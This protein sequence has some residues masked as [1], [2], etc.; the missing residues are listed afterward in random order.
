[1]DLPRFVV[2]VLGQTPTWQQMELYESVQRPGSRTSVS[3]GHGSGKTAAMA[4]VA[5]WMLTTYV[6]SNTI[7]SGPKLEILLSG[8]RKYFSDYVPF[9]ESGPYGWIVKYIVIA[10]KTIYIRGFKSQ[11][12]ITA[13]TAPSGKPEA[14]AGEHRRHLTWLLDESSGVD[15]KIMGVILGSLTEEW[16]RIALMSQPTRASG[17]FYD[18]HHRLSEKR[19]GAWR[20]ITM[21][22]EE[23]PLVSDGFIA[24]KLMQ[25]GGRDDPQ[26]QIKVLGQFPEN[27]EGQLLSRKALENCVAKPSVMK[28]TDEWGWVVSVDV[29]AGEERDKS[30]V[31]VSK[32]SGRGQFHEAVPRKVHV[33]DIPICSSTIQPTSLIGEIIRIAAMYP[34]C[35]VLVDAVG[36][37]LFVYKKLEELGLPG[38]IKVNWGAP[39]WLRTMKETFFNQR[40]Q[41]MVCAA[42]AAIHGNLSIEEKAF[43]D[44]RTRNEFLDQSRI[45]YH[46]TDLGQYKIEPKGSKDWEGIPSP[47]MFDALSF[48]FLE[49]AIYIPSA[50]SASGKDDSG[51]VDAAVE[52]MKARRAAL[53]KAAE[54]QTE[55]G[56]ETA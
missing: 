8:V 15:D 30:V 24:E 48:N 43:Q 46:F 26:Y 52:R 50:D 19:G 13:K 44:M 38:L 41:A 56:A 28:K 40:A 36:M 55:E 47:D 18:T 34:N 35:I 1:M 33:Q 21:S 9:V 39:C 14:I 5:W 7:L 17:F 11:W 51:A 23:S 27:L 31:M 3:S 2:E 10:H 6:N 49:S 20:S 53:K 16:N 4:A 45:P 32:V 54:D 12:W 37:G 22:S 25:Y 42:R 29:A